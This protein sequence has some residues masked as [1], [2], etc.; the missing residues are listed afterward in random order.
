MQ[1][2]RYH[3]YEL[4]LLYAN[5]YITTPDVSWCFN[6]VDGGS[7]LFD[8]QLPK[9]KITEIQKFFLPSIRIQKAID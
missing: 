2:T 3:N 4:S 5:D 7:L 6:E 8:I 9:C 1:Q